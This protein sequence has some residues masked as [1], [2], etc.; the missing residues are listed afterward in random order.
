MGRGNHNAPPPETSRPFADGGASERNQ[1]DW[2]LRSQSN[3]GERIASIETH[4]IHIANSLDK[5]EKMLEKHGEATTKINTK[6][7]VAA[8]VMI[9]VGAVFA[10]LIDGKLG[11]LSSFMEQQQ[12]QQVQAAPPK[13]DK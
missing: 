13:T 2:V 8:A 4:N 9:T 1:L 12:Q 11:K 5:I 3:L 6:L 7:A 10:F